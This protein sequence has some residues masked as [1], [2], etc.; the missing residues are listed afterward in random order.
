MVVL[1]EL[2]VVLGVEGV[3]DV[4]VGA[5]VGRR[6]FRLLSRSPWVVLSPSL[7]GFAEDHVDIF[8]SVM[9]GY[10]IIMLR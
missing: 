10:S 4:S 9:I 3:L 2:A 7:I 8:S 1:G 5:S 6:L